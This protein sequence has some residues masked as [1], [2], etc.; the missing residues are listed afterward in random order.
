VPPPSS[1]WDGA[2]VVSPVPTTERSSS[3][4]SSG[5]SL[6]GVSGGS[7]AGAG[8][9]LASSSSAPVSPSAGVSSPPSPPA[10]V[11]RH[12]HNARCWLSCVGHGTLSDVDCVHVFSMTNKQ[13]FRRR[14]L[15]A[16]G[17]CNS[18]D[19]TALLPCITSSSCQYTTLCVRRASVALKG[20][21]QGQMLDH[22]LPQV[23]QENSLL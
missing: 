5:S 16:T 9:A 23:P 10:E 13:A 7:G 2:S 1:S 22:M 12:Q 3:G 15:L 14:A 18:S 19:S 17:R 11:R 6:G 4:G 20:C 21:H 8:A